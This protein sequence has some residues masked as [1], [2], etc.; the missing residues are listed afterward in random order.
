MT[1]IDIH[2]DDYCLSPH[3]SEEIVDCIR[4]GKL[5]SISVVTNMS[6]YE[7]YARKFLQERNSFKRVPKLSIHLNFMEGHCIA[8]EEDVQELVD[9]NGYFSISWGNLFIWNYSP[10][11]YIE[12]KRQLKAEIKAQTDRFIEIFGDSQALR[13]DSHQHTHMIPICYWALL[14]VI[15]EQCYKTEYIRITKEP[16]SPY[17]KNFSLWKTY[18]PI[19]W[20]KNFVLNFYALFMEKTIEKNKPSWQKDNVPMLLWGI[21][22]SG[23]MDKERVYKLWPDMEHRAEKS[24]R[25]LEILFHPG[26]ATADEMGEEF[27]NKDANKFY[28]SQGRHLEYECVLSLRER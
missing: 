11:K 10:K 20:I 21:I 22:M 9:K 6:C 23:R 12:I 13:F 16:I 19:N 15:V 14:E 4:A 8:K 17:L 18:K 5:D 26:S 25:C 1:K 27:C 2:A 3:T 28:V 7:Q 24:G